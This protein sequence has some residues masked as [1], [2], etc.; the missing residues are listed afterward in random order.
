MNQSRVSLPV[1]TMWIILCFAISAA[2]LS[3]SVQ[4]YNEPSPVDTSATADARSRR[5][6][7]LLYYAGNSY[8]TLLQDEY[9]RQQQL[10]QEAEYHRQQ[11]ARQTSYL[12]QQAEVANVER[13]DYSMAGYS[14]TNGDS[15]QFF[16]QYIPQS[17][18]SYQQPTYVKYVAQTPSSPKPTASLPKFKPIP[19]PSP[20]PA[21][22]Y[23]NTP[24]TQPTNQQQYE[25][26]NDGVQYY[27]RP[28]H[29][30]QTIEPQ[31]Q[32]RVNL[33]SVYKYLQLQSSPTP[34]P[35][36]NVVSTLQPQPYQDNTNQVQYQDLN[37]PQQ[38]QDSS[39]VQYKDAP[40]VQYKDSSNEQYKDSSNVQYQD[41]SNQ[42]YQDSDPSNHHY[43]QE[44]AH[45][46]TLD[47]TVY[48]KYYPEQTKQQ[49]QQ[50]Q[51]EE[52]FH[53]ER[54][55]LPLDNKPVQHQHTQ[56]QSPVGGQ[57]QSETYPTKESHRFASTQPSR[58]PKPKVS[59]NKPK[60]TTSVT[61]EKSQ[62]LPLTHVYAQ[63]DDSQREQSFN[64]PTK[65]TKLQKVQPSYTPEYDIPSTTE[66]YYP[67][68]P[69]V[70]NIRYASQKS[71]PSPFQSTVTVT[72]KQ[73]N[74]YISTTTPLYPSTPLYSSN[75][76][77]T[78]E[79]EDGGK[80]PFDYLKKF[81]I[82]K[83]ENYEIPLTS[84]TG[85][86]KVNS[87]STTKRPQTSHTKPNSFYDPYVK[88][89]KGSN[90]INPATLFSTQRPRPQEQPQ[91]LSI[92]PPQ[93]EQK[94][95]EHIGTL[96]QILKGH[97]IDKT[98]PEKVTA[99]NI[100]SSI[101]TLTTI[102]KVLQKNPGGFPVSP[103]AP[104]KNQHFPYT[105][106]LDNSLT[107]N[108][109]PRTQTY[110]DGSTPGRPGVDYPTLFEI[111]ETSFDC[112]TQRYK[113][114]FG[115][116]ET[117]CQVWHYCDLNG[118]Q[119]SFLCPN[120]TIF[121]QVALTCDWWF[122]VK[123]NSTAQLY[124]LNERLYKF[125][126]PTKPSF[127][128]DYSGPEVDEYLTQKFYELEAKRKGSNETTLPPGTTTE[129]IQS[130]DLQ[131][132]FLKRDVK[133]QERLL[134]RN[135]NEQ[136]RTDD[137]SEE[138]RIVKRDINSEE[139]TQDINSQ[140]QGSIFNQQSNAQEMPFKRDI[141]SEERTWR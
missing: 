33:E 94:Y 79:E 4:S 140:V 37:Q 103:G 92:L 110:T 96:T 53:P 63:N 100:D 7:P 3:G 9:L 41:T 116:P 57:Y 58:E 132:N 51:E 25:V 121:N 6:V 72:P 64:H 125:I 136:D 18:S 62:E 93:E 15:G 38:Y 76:V 48:Q 36:Y 73:Q 60:P 59:P 28:T 49:Q 16:K 130:N 23:V 119:A 65:P 78:T 27:Y 138:T 85:P 67:M 14:Y 12:R 1:T 13:K 8:D 106:S 69:F 86:S 112:K 19:S 134:K 141:N 50:Q 123:C 126:I 2:V 61:I 97:Q 44:P 127:P 120:G 128:E 24:P 135:A 32:N 102:L 47:Q 54:Q 17:A 70:E 21:E 90:K 113:G 83:G 89:I 55:Y 82:G 114:F 68:Q 31:Q 20:S 109:P 29:S 74:Y 10:Q 129:P 131:D 35:L 122:N 87:F 95:R 104:L 105:G 99:D 108:P 46:N 71:K 139:R 111:P 117:D 84:F 75:I 40:N 81:Q 88:L 80:S 133:A 45:Q 66:A 42:Q 43:F 22:Y 124:V 77:S 52:S 115:D 39:N 101:D 107:F 26:V 118:G 11:R 137:S 56:Y 34:T 5:L 30:V 98:L 91:D